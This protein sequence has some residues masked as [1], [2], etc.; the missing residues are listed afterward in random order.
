[1]QWQEL[2]S[3]VVVVVLPQGHSVVVLVVGA[4]VVV[5]VGTA[6]VVGAAV[7]V[8]QLSPSKDQAWPAALQIH[9]QRPWQVCSDSGLGVVVVLVVV[10][11]ASSTS[12][13]LLVGM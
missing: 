7:V 9:L 12:Q 4:A 8:V 13:C 6:V 2:G 5:L 10:V 1:M 11:G 3:G